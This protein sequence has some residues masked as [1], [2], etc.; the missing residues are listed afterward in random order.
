MATVRGTHGR[1]YPGIAFRKEIDAIH[2][3][4][5]FCDSMVNK[6]VA[7]F[8]CIDSPFTVLVSKGACT[9]LPCSSAG[10]ADKQ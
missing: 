3:R 5:E 2:I 9:L 7:V 10:V 4:D 1:S 8:N 6:S